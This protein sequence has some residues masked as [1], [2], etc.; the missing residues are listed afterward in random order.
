MNG[1]CG[2]PGKW[3]V[4]TKKEGHDDFILDLLNDA[5]MRL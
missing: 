5:V 3:Q 1:K 2:K 4:A